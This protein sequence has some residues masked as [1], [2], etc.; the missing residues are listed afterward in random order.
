MIEEEEDDEARSPRHERRSWQRTRYTL[1]TIYENSLSRVEAED[2]SFI[3]N[4]TQPQGQS[5][6]DELSSEARSIGYSANK[7]NWGILEPDM[8]QR[9]ARKE[10]LYP[11]SDS[12]NGSRGKNFG[13]ASKTCDMNKD[14]DLVH[15]GSGSTPSKSRRILTT[16]DVNEFQQH[17]TSIK[18]YGLKLEF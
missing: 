13:S 18:K 14:S 9:S 5:D 4:N 1:S 12:K 7:E 8:L 16:V 3:R 10:E 17:Q 15:V 11:D 2:H 6:A